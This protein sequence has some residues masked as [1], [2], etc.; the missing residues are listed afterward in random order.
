MF[1]VLIFVLCFLFCLFVC[2]AE[3][4]QDSSLV[5]CLNEKFHIF[6]FLPKQKNESI[7]M[8]YELKLLYAAGSLF[9]SETGNNKEKYN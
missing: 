4:G 3:E 8:A 7:P 5:W 2:L 9:W 1:L 6:Y